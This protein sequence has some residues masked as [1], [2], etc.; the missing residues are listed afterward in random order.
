M[1]ASAERITH[2]IR[3]E[4]RHLSQDRRQGVHRTVGRLFTEV[5]AALPSTGVDFQPALNNVERT[6]TDPSVHDQ[7]TTELGLMTLTPEQQRELERFPTVLR[8]LIEAELAAGNTI[9]EV[10]R[11]FPAPP[12]G[13]YVQLAW[14]VTTRPRAPG[15]GLG[16]R[17]R[18][19]A[20]AFTDTGQFYFVL[21][22]P[23]PI[24]P[25]P[26]M[27]AIRA[28]HEMASKDEQSFDH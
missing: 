20:G 2:Y 10:G 1:S 21:D 7:Y 16:F 6:F 27:D 15:N 19:S 26:D 28:A 23:S 3:P 4:W 14:Q 24:P 25:P 12:A 8:E 17:E 22:P 5:A 11:S 18:S 13:A 9:T